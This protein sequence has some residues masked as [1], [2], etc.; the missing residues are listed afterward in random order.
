[1][2]STT[3]LYSDRIAS[4][5]RDVTDIFVVDKEGKVH[6]KM[7][8]SIDP[9]KDISNLIKNV[10]GV[11]T[12]IKNEAPSACHAVLY[13][14]E[15]K[16]LLIFREEQTVGVIIARRASEG[17]IL[18]AIYKTL[19]WIGSEA[20]TDSV[21]LAKKKT[22]FIMN[23]GGTRSPFAAS[24]HGQVVSG[25]NTDQVS[26]TAPVAEPMQAKP[27]TESKVEAASSKAGVPIGL[28]VA[29]ILVAIL[30]GVGVFIVLG[31]K[32]E[33]ETAVVDTPQSDRVDPSSALPAVITEPETMSAAVV[34]GKIAEAKADID[35]YNTL[36]SEMKLEAA[37]PEA[38]AQAKVA[39]AGAV[40]LGD[41]VDQIVAVAWEEAADAVGAAI[42]TAL[43]NKM[44]A[45]VASITVDNPTGY[46][47][48]TLVELEGARQAAE[49]ALAQSDY[50][51]AVYELKAAIVAA[52]AWRKDIAAQLLAMGRAAAVNREV[53]T[54]KV[55]FLQL[56]KLEPENEEA[57]AYL[58]RH[59]Y[60]TGELITNSINMKLAF[61]PPGEVR[62]GSPLS[63]VGRDPDEVAFTVV[64][65]Q[66]LFIG[67][68]EVT[69][70]QWGKVM[71]DPLRK[72]TANSSQASGF[73]GPSMPMH[74]ITY[75][76]AVEFCERLSAMEGKTYRLPTEAEWE[77]ACR[78]DTITPFA[79]GNTSMTPQ[80]ANY[81]NPAAPRESPVVSGSMRFRNAFGLSD[82]HGNLW[83]WV[84][85]WYDTYPEGVLTDYKGPSDQQI[86]R[87]DLA[88]KVARGGSWNDDML[89]ARSANR[90][91]FSPV[92]PTNYIGFRV[93]MEINEF[94][95]QNQ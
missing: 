93:V 91:Q 55:F 9:A 92:V 48:P 18:E 12:S 69:Q 78:A 6:E 76:E 37:A 84:S 77:Y 36:I 53:A 3:R 43:N 85:D 65:T 54:G 31:K 57:I 29:S 22:P 56:L 28:I 44:H 42:V 95:E 24:T 68:T 13:Y 63:E 19:G 49:I 26:Q 41:K 27:L 40:R 11:V 62:M 15:R 35:E 75:A 4:I 25:G 94:K 66:G 52:T 71:G 80:E 34:S 67:T 89:I 74:G 1:M 38:F 50:K 33:V 46:R 81:H 2:T 32:D 87:P 59:F 10:T 64:L 47:F 45:V 5:S 72:V 61:V 70:E 86:G 82:M 51:R 73:I 8:R 79:N 21:A 83:E 88:M 23:L 20:G 17:Q 60:R 90:A 14:R 58:H 16:L 30:M 39:L 7:F